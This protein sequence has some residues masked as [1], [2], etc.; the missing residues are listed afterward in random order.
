M[1]GLGVLL[2]L[3]GGCAAALILIAGYLLSRG[4]E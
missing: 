3:I 4:E 1:N 2:G